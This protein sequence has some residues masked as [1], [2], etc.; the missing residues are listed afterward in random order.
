MK[1]WTSE[2]TKHLVSKSKKII[3]SV[4]VPVV[5]EGILPAH[6]IFIP[7]NCPS[8]KNSKSV[9]V[10]KGKG[11]LVASEPVRKYI[12][13]AT[14]DYVQNKSLFLKMS[15]N[16]SKPL[17]VNFYFVRKTKQ[18][19]DYINAAQIVLDSMVKAEWIPDDNMNEIV[20]AFQGFHVDKNMPGVYIYF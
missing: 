19:F 12:K 11:N 16:H 10:V 14:W 9:F 2:N 4:P 15:K 13:A 8:L 3:K 20:P 18:R 6:R 5:P 1:G 17:K 7:G